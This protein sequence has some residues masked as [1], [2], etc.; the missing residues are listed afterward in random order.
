MGFAIWCWKF[1]IGAQLASAILDGITSGS[2]V[3]YTFIERYNPRD[4]LTHFP[5]GFA[6]QQMRPLRMGRGGKFSQNFPFRPGLGVI[7]DVAAEVGDLV[8]RK[9]LLRALTGCSAVPPV[10]PDRVVTWH[11]WAS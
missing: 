3:L 8:L 4:F 5:A 2:Q 7:E 11:A 6:T 9:K 10:Q 1:P